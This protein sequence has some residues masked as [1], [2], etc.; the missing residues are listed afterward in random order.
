MRPNSKVQEESLDSDIKNIKRMV[1]F[2]MSQ[3]KKGI[4]NKKKETTKGS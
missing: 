3:Y 2:L 4:E 1:D